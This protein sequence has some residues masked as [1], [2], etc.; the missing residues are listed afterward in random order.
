MRSRWRI[1]LLVMCFDI[2]IILN[3]YPIRRSNKLAFI[4]ITQGTITLLAHSLDYFFHFSST[5]GLYRSSRRKM[6]LLLYSSKKHPILMV[7]VERVSVIIILREL[8]EKHPVKNLA[9]IVEASYSHGDVTSIN[10][11]Q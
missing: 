3:L 8:N 9:Q 5:T 2:S 10:I 6:L 4:V 1:S 7:T 11:V